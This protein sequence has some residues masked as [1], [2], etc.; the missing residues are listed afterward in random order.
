MPTAYQN[1]VTAMRSMAE[2]MDFQPEENSTFADFFIPATLAHGKQLT[3]FGT[4]DRLSFTD[5]Q[6]TE[7]V[8]LAMTDPGFFDT[9]VSHVSLYIRENQPMPEAFQAFALAAMSGQIVRPSPPHREPKRNFSTQLGIYILL[10]EAHQCHGL[11][12]TRNDASGSVSAC[13]AVVDALDGLVTYSEVKNLCVHP[14][15]AALREKIELYFMVA[16]GDDRVTLTHVP[17]ELRA[18]EDL[19]I[20]TMKQVELLLAKANEFLDTPGTE[21]VNWQVVLDQWEELADLCG[22]IEG[23]RFDVNGLSHDMRAALDSVKRILQQTEI[24]RN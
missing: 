22:D 18:Q 3:E 13:D 23:T 15:K 17:K 6:A 21:A 12:L 9:C 2:R 14:A 5:D 24:K 8:R 20:D 4:T 19:A 16:H 1:A 10:V 7:F 11:T